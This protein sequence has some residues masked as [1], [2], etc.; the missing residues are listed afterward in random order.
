MRL[1]YTIWSATPTPF[2]DT[3]EL[4]GPALGRLVEQHLQL[5]VSG[6]FLA[7]TCG[8][9]PFMPNRQRNELVRHV[10]RLAGDRLTL[11]VQ[12][13]DTSAARVRENMAYA[14]DAGADFAVIERSALCSFAVGVD[15]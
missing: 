2:L 6:L 8:E 10:R 4:D 14:E 3:G 5:E 9:G 7:G 11:A 15:G 1:P 12:V 13:S